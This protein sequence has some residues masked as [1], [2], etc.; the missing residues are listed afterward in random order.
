[1]AAKWGNSNSM[2]ATPRYHAGKATNMD[3]VSQW[4]GIVPWIVSESQLVLYA[5]DAY[6]RKQEYAG[7]PW[8]QPRNE[9]PALRTQWAPHRSLAG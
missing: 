8:E 7:Y 5:G 9:T 6:E 1:M 3:V 2:Y 4:W